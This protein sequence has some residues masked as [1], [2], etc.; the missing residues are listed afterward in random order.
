MLPSMRWVLVNNHSESLLAPRASNSP[1]FT[2]PSSKSIPTTKGLPWAINYYEDFLILYPDSPLVGDAE[3]ALVKMKE[4]Y[5]EN[6][7]ITADFYYTRKN[8]RVA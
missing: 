4:I 2:H 1:T 6:K 5:A 7:L 3:K 8:Q